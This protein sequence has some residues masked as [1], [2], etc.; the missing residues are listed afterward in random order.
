MAS[1]L[2]RCLSFPNDSQKVRQIA[3]T[4]HSMEL[5]LLHCL[6]HLIYKAVITSLP[7]APILQ[8]QVY[9]IALCTHFVELVLPHCRVHVFFTQLPGTFNLLSWVYSNAWCTHS[10]KL[11]IHYCLCTNSVQLG[12]PHCLVRP[13][14][15]ACLPHCLVHQ[16]YRAGST[17]LPGAF[18]LYSWVYT[19]AWCTHFI[20]P[21]PR[22]CL[23]HPF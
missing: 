10:I 17:P 5:G 2:P 3:W 15:I 21:G 6:V 4:T 7:C 9:P 1:S 20:K 8:S 12:L 18:I 16:F 11:E 23:V 22:H 14:Y 19:I 13:I